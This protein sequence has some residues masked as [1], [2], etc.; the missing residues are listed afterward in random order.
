MSTQEKVSTHEKGSALERA[1]A[2]YLA[3][4]GYEVHS[5]VVETGRWGS[6]HELDVL[7]V[8]HDAVGPIRVVVECK[9]WAGPVG[10]ETVY[11][12]RGVLEDL[13]ATKGIIAAASGFT[14][15]AALAA[16]Q[17]GVTLWGPDELAS[18]LGQLALD[19]LR[20]GTAGTPALGWARREVT[21]A[22]RREVAKAA[23][24][25]LGVFGREKVAWLGPLWVPV[26]VA[27]VAET[28]TV[29]RFKAVPRVTR[30]ALCYEA[31]TGRWVGEATGPC[32]PVDL[33]GGYLP[34][35]VSAAKATAPL[36]DA[37]ARWQLVTS[38]AAKARHAQAM[39]EHGVEAPVEHVE[40]EGA[41]LA[42]LPLWAGW[43]TGSSGERVVAV[44]GRSGKNAPALSAVLTTNVARVREVLAVQQ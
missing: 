24:G 25:A 15:Q 10:K 32:E 3:S 11:K 20:A 38:V 4:E 7:G 35:V 12:L 39:A 14:P 36:L 29:G 2:A 1:V 28:R 19:G 26:W 41:E 17:T 21:A 33:D 40:V 30:A 9:A 34:P 6:A 22:A 5:N 37:F 23:R 27:T 43:L 18:R 42:F 13:A 44:D 8:K 31:L 16:E